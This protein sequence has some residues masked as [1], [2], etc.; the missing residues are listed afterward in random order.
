MSFLGKANAFDLTIL[1]RKSRKN[2][3]RKI[4]R[5][6]L[7]LSISAPGL[8]FQVTSK[9]LFT[10]EQNRI[11]SCFCTTSKDWKAPL[12]IHGRKKRKP[13]L[14]PQVVKKI[15][16]D[17][18]IYFHVKDIGAYGNPIFAKTKKNFF[19]LRFI[20]DLFKIYL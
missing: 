10:D 1:P 13:Q 11:Y 19:Y 9:N 17:A 3:S 16:S 6:S 12:L 4:S 7:A 5:C 15:S 2:N 18:G 20:Y 14:G 8:H